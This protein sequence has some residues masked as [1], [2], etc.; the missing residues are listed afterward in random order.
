MFTFSKTKKKFAAVAAR[1]DELERELHQQQDQLAKVNDEIKECEEGSH[2]LNDCIQAERTARE[3]AEKENATLEHELQEA[4]AELEALRE[5][6]HLSMAAT[7]AARVEKEGLYIELA[8]AERIIQEE[9]AGVEA[10]AEAAVQEVAS[11]QAEQSEERRRWESTRRAHEQLQQH[12]KEAEQQRDLAKAERD[13]AKEKWVVVRDELQDLQRSN[14]RL[15]DDCV[16]NDV[17]L[18]EERAKRANLQKEL[19]SLTDAHATI[20]QQQEVQ[21]AHHDTCRNLTAVSGELDSKRDS[22]QRE[23]VA[24]EQQFQE[25]KVQRERLLVESNETRD[26]LGVFLPEYFALQTEHAS[27][28]RELEH[29]RRQHDT[30]KW[31]H[32]KVL[33]DLGM[34]AK[35]YDAGY[36]PSILPE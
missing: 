25:A 3:L 1:K 21:M 23:L 33:R 17:K 28:Q 15:C 24:F 2:Q 27:H 4:S 13:V 32:H 31:E 16:R 30:L 26:A 11:L 19:A 5:K 36:A 10:S 8:G 18:A 35:S 14:R 29:E 34:L 7:E 6:Y 12:M 22:L 9:H 20:Q